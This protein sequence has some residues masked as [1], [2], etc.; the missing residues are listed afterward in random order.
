NF[1][2]AD[3]EQRA[4]GAGSSPENSA[5]ARRKLRKGERLCQKVVGAGIE[6]ANA[7]FR[8]AR[9]RDPKDPQIRLLRTNVAK[10]IESALRG[11]IEIQNDEI[12]RLVKSQTLG[13]PTV[14]N[15]LYGEL[16]LLQP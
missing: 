8:E 10:N 1:Q 2:I 4:A 14:R 15:H 6:Q 5:D 3:L 11:Q 7:I 16:F 13:F 12:V 9:C